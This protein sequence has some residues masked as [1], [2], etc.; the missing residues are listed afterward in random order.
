MEELK[1]KYGDNQQ[2]LNKATMEMYRKEGVNPLSG[3][4]SGCFPMLLQMPVFFALYVVL[5]NS[6]DLRGA[7]FIGWITNLSAPDPWRILPILMGISMFFQQKQT[8]MG[9]SL[10]SSSQQDQQKMMKW[11]MP[12]FLTFIFFRLPAGV[13]LYWLSFNIFT[14]LQQMLIKK[15]EHVPSPVIGH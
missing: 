11:M 14:S 10:G 6:I 8:G 7:H 13:V 12:I 9:S 1:K 4:K 3:C 5:Y 15:K 2:K